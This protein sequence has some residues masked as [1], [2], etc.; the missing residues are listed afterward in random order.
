MELFS[1]GAGTFQ[2]ERLII[3]TLACRCH[4]IPLE[5]RHDT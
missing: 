1:D 2:A 3:K 4:G 5:C